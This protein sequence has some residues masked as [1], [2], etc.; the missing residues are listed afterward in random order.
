M[1]QAPWD[2]L[3]LTQGFAAPGWS[4]RKHL[5]LLFLCRGHR[6][7]RLPFCCLPDLLDL[8][9]EGA[10]VDTGGWVFFCFF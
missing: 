8:G 1:V 5:R 3:R 6:L 7:Q 4:R 2:G 10:S 9:M